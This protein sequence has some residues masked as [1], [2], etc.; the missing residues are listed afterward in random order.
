MSFTKTYFLCP[1]SDFIHPPPFG[2][3]LL[4]SILRSTSA[5]QYPLNKTDIVPVNNL[6]PPIVET[7]WKKTVS[8]QTAVS[9]GV[10]AQLLQLETGGLGAELDVERSTLTEIVFAFD[11]L[12]TM[13]FDPSPQYVQEAIKAPAVQTWL[14]EP[15]QRLAPV[16]SLYLVTGMKLV[17]GAKIKYSTGAS[18]AVAGNFGVDVAPIGMAIGPKGHWSKINDDETKFSRKSEFVFAIRVK[19]LR[20]G[21]SLKTEDYNK[22]AFLAIGKDEQ[23]DTT[24]F[25]ED[26]DGSSIQSAQIVLDEAENEGVYCVP[27]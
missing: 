4:G 26:V 5:P 6:D 13:S 10:Y 2:P 11:N 19:K 3:L 27:G 24:I 7:D 22:G 18:T 8:A 17:K 25:I 14:R 1:T 21:R 12:T 23:D 16:S 20:I 9:V 15:K